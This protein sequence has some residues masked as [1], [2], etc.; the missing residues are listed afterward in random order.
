MP[1]DFEHYFVAHSD[2]GLRPEY[3]CINNEGVFIFRKQPPALD[4][5]RLEDFGCCGG[6]GHE[7]RLTLATI[8]PHAMCN[9]PAPAFDTSHARHLQ[10]YVLDLV[11]AIKAAE[12]NLKVKLPKV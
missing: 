1:L 10:R 12:L 3:I 11:N 9:G 8:R 7:D 6:G 5:D 4:R 2:I